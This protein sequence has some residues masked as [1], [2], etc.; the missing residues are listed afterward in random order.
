MNFDW[1]V[2]WRNADALA[3]GTKL[4]VLLAVTTMAIISFALP[5]VAALGGLAGLAFAFW[6]DKALLQAY[7]P[8]DSNG[9]N[10]SSSPDLRILLFNLA[11]TVLTGVIFGLVPALQT[12]RP[13]IVGTLKDQAGA[14]VGGG[15]HRLR[16][17][18]VVAQV[19]L[20]LL[21]L[22][23]AGLFVRSLSN[24]RNLGPGFPAARSL[25]GRRSRPGGSA[26]HA[27]RRRSEHAG[28]SC[29]GR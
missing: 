8:S 22:I 26:A 4:T 28:R 3:E 24:L 6:A 9:L 23:A 15:H 7:L 20:S 16:K 1:S 2:V 5:A 27:R 29:R 18:L 17:A 12:T 10:I 11:V 21:L 19:T 13:N 25:M 14:V